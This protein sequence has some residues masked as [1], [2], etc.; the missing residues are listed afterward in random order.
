MQA[1]RLTYNSAVSAHADTAMALVDAALRGEQASAEM[2]EAAAKT[3]SLLDDS[4]AR[5]HAVMA[6]AMGDPAS[7]EL[8]DCKQ[9]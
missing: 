3:K 7:P 6:L 1:L 5:L 2:I 8:A 4:R 9:P